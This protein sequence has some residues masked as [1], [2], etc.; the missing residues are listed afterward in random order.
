[1]LIFTQARSSGADSGS[2]V[3]HGHGSPELLRDAL[4]TDFL[5]RGANAIQR[6]SALSRVRRVA[7]GL[8]AAAALAGCSHDSAPWQLTDVTGHLPDLSFSLTADDGKPV[9]GAT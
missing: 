7:L 2:S 4:Q 1:M 9:T 6:P 5:H 3:R 8:L